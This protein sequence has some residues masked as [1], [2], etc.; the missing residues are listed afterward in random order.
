[1]DVFP[2]RLLLPVFSSLPLLCTGYMY[3]SSY[4]VCVAEYKNTLTHVSLD[5]GME[6]GDDDADGR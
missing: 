1:M 4:K 2:A 5:G 3:C 6:E